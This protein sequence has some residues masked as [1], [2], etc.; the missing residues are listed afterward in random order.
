MCDGLDN[1]CDGTVDEDAAWSDLGAG[2]ISSRGECAAAGVLVCDPDDPSGALVC[3]GDAGDPVAEVCDGLDN[4]CDGAVDEDAVWASVGTACTNGEGVC[5]R[6]G[7]F[8]CDAT[9]PAGAPVCGATPGTPTTEVCD[10][11]D[12]DCDGSTDEGGTWSNLGLGCTSGGGE[13]MAAGVF[14][15]DPDNRGGPTICSGEPGEEGVEVCDSLDNDCDGSV[16]E[17]PIWDT[18]GTVCVVGE[19][20]CQRAGVLVCNADSPAGPPVCNATPGATSTEICDGLDNDCDGSTDEDTIWDTVGQG[21]T[22]GDGICRAAGVLVCDPDDRSGVPV[23]SAVPGASETEVCDGVDNDCDGSIDEDAIWA[24]LG[25]VCTAGDGICEA[26]GILICNPADLGGAPVCNATIGTA[27]TEVCDG[28]DNDCDGS[29]DE[30]P[31]WDDLGVGCT[32]G[33]GIC[34]AAGVQVCNP[35]DRGGA[36]V[37]SATPGASSTEVCDGLDNDC[38]GSTDE[39]PIWSTLGNVCT[40]GD[41]VCERAGVLACNPDD[42]AGAPICNAVP[43]ASGTE[44]CDGLDNDCDGSTDEGA[45]WANLGVGC[46]SGQGQC[47]AAG[48][49]VC[50]TDDTAGAPI[51]SATPGDPVAEVC[52]GL[53]NDCD[54]STDETFGGLGDTCFEGLGI[55]RSAGVV[56]CDGPSATECDAVV[57]DPA[58]PDELS[59]DYLDD[60]C[61]GSI[62]EDFIT[63]G[64]YRSVE[65][66]GGCGVACA[67]L[68]DGGPAA[69]H[70][71][72]V[73]S[74][75][76][77]VASC[78]YTCETGW[79][80]LDLDPANGCEF[81][82]DDGA[83]YVATAANGGTD[84][85]SCGAWDAP[86]RTIGYAITRADPTTRPRVRVSDGLYREN[87]LLSNGISVLGGHNSVNWLRN[88]SVNVSAITGLNTAVD[89]ATL[90]AIGITA[91]TKL[92]GFT[93]TAAPGRTGGGNSSGVYV[94][95]ANG[96]LTIR[97]NVIFAASGGDGT[98]GLVGSS[99]ANGSGGSSGN[100][101][102]IRSPC[103]GS[104][105]G[106]VAGTNSCTNPS[107]GGST[108]TDGGTGGV[109]T[110]PSFGVQTGSGGAGSG[111]SP[112]GGGA[113]AFSMLGSGSSCYVSGSVDPTPGLP[114]NPGTDG[115]GGSGSTDAAGAVSSGRWSGSGGTGGSVGG[116]GSGGGGG[117]AA[118]GV[119]TTGDDYFGAT[120]GGGGSGGCAAGGGTSGSAGGASFAIFVA[121]SS[122]PGSSGAMPTILDNTLTRGQGG[123][124]GSG[125][126]GGAGGEPG[127]GAAGGTGVGGGTYG[128]CMLDGAVGAEGGRGGHGGGGG[129]G[130]GGVSF[131]LFAWNANGHDPGYSGNTFGLAGGTATGGDGG[132]GGTSNNTDNVGGT[133][134]DGLFGNIRFDDP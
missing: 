95:D 59:C 130:G 109:S 42:T 49:L 94:R 104:I 41:G 98:S 99:G 4:D 107:G 103:T 126:N 9:D 105:D 131:D 17:D 30:N 64:L 106:G 100:S 32:R 90:T 132:S 52:D 101:S 69:F 62:D 57:P 85:G 133:G 39:N 35:D 28:L 15:C 19:G 124:G 6:A 134:T 48:V 122:T 27:E 67:D 115:G 72:P 123:R 25:G 112:G 50:D 55:C 70:V 110:C 84:S 36:T 114:G 73:C 26:A 80:D 125:G 5:V 74:V 92:S 75:F 113:G 37:C 23:C 79:H 76:L 7:V 47:I 53:D 82:P 88:P 68:W 38:D 60:D 81:T 128:F 129:G 46:T 29:V 65:H 18:I 24:D 16:D 83:V 87:V 45:T 86:C 117:G 56:V 61:D 40:N 33:D 63:D 93:I 116:Q 121:F 20:V 119:E 2:C 10:G 127:A 78:D 89:N 71:V 11:L 31:I 43:G 21:C 118:A 77:L 66:C 8:A 22:A 44:V 14:V 51:C 3:S 96:S 102:E 12:N 120:G 97:D 111:P 34:R 58:S 13:C 1:D 108:T 91:T 54:G